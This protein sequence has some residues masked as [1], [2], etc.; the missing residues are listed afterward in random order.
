MNRRESRRCVVAQDVSLVWMKNEEE[1][2]KEELM[3]KKKS[4]NRI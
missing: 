2:D 4:E 3:K 1:K